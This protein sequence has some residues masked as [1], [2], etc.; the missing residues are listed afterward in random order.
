VRDGTERDHFHSCAS[1]H[2]A[3]HLPATAIV[4]YNESERCAHLIGAVFTVVMLSIRSCKVAW[5]LVVAVVL[6]YIP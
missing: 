4:R 2:F 3:L 5:M 1:E 6:C